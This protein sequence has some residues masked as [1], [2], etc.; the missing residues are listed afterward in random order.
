M[1]N[2]I[3]KKVKISVI[4]PARNE[5]K[6]IEFC[7]NSVKSQNFKD[8]EI[9]VVDNGSTDK[10]SEI[11]KKLGAKVVFEPRVGLPRA[12][13]TGRRAANGEILLY[14][15]AD[16]IIPPSHL[17]K[18]SEFFANH[19]EA[20]ATTN[21]YTFYDGNWKT[22]IFIWFVFKFTFP[23][24][25]WLL[26][27]FKLPQFVLGGSF[28]V[29]KYILEKT[30]GFN[31]NLT[32]YGEDADIS[33]RI[34]KQ[35][36]I[37]FLPG[38]RTSTSARRY[39][40]QGFLKTQSIYLY[41]HLSIFL[42]NQF[43]K[44]SFK[45]LHH[46][47]LL[48]F[49]TTLCGLGLV[50]LF[51]YASTSLKSEVFGKVIHDIDT[52]RKIVALTFDDGPNGKY[53]Q[54]VIDILDRE[55][56]KATFFLIGKNVETYPEIAKE[57]A[58]H[59]HAIGNHS[60]THPWLLPLEKKKSIL[61][62][63]DKAEAAIYKATGESPRLFRPPHGLRSFWMDDIIRREGYTI[64][65]WDD[66]TKDYLQGTCEKKIA[67]RILSNIHPG[68]IIVLHDGVN[69]EHGI[70]RENMIEALPEII[71]ELKKEGYE[72]VTLDENMED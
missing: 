50:A 61:Q 7:I 22:N 36:L 31:T 51:A 12:R 43:P 19:S 21:P 16:T 37:A 67:R 60:Y 8:Y 56:V 32:F 35:G 59:G 66:M 48:R 24:Y 71:R 5:E 34:S 23:L 49:A 26:G 11:A 20:V 52:P 6:Y 38:L 14:I 68:S 62:E 41:N 70:N 13:E 47:W 1:N 15:D 9:I 42:S 17:S 54:Q 18:V 69:L 25:H 65:T 72:F 28:A 53:T 39:L 10:T 55:G 58:V 29:R 46:R 30:G 64:F 45:W 2:S 63:V 40:S 3:T 33:I 27:A 44:R 57:I 4:I